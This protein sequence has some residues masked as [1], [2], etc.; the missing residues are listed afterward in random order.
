[1]NPPIYLIPGLGAD[2]RNYPG[3][4][5]EL[6]NCTALD[7]PEY[8]GKACMQEAARFMA[9]AWKLPPHA[10]LVGTS[11][12]GMLACEMAKFLPVHAVVLIASTTARENFTTTAKMKRLL[13]MV[14]LRL[15]QRVL[16]GAQPVLEKIWGRAPTPVA[17]GVLDSIQMF[18]VC[19]PGF[20]RN[21][22]HAI[23]T[24]EGLKDTTVSV[25]RI[26]GRQDELILPP[27]QADL[28]L[29]GG[30]LIVMTHARECVNFI[31]SWL[32]REVS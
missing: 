12:G 9:E 29:E 2:H 31:Q 23:S 7:W 19:Q 26:H 5:Q 16:R 27:T 18:S 30:H 32:K 28:F 22:F 14:W 8:H 20:Y 25:V 13:R 4:W 17:R 21:M 6:P 1:M 11:F 10:I 24:W 15:A 3:P